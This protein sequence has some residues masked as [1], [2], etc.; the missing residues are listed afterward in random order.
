MWDSPGD[1][2]PAAHEGFP[3]AVLASY[4]FNLDFQSDLVFWTNITQVAGP[5][6]DPACRL[7]S[8]VQT[9]T[10]TI[11]FD[12]TFDNL[13]H[14]HIGTAL[15]IALTQDGDATR[16]STPVAGS[17]LEIRGPISLNVL[18]VDATT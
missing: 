15:T 9:N 7:Y 16:V 6:P 11:R 12:C 13:G 10:W 2:C 14:I 8:S 17:G 3:G 5:T 4:R 18:V 1:S